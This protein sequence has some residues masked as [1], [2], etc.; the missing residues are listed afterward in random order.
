MLPYVPFGAP[1]EPPSSAA[2]R[3][4]KVMIANLLFRNVATQR[5]RE[6]VRDESPDVLLLIEFTPTWADQ[7]AELRDVYPYR[8]EK[9]E[10]GAFGMALLSRYELDPVAPLP[11]GATLAIQ[12]TI[13][14]PAGPF[15][16]IGVHL[17]SPTSRAWRCPA[18]P[19][20]RSP[21]SA[22]GQARRTSRRGRGFQR[23][24]VFAVLDRLARAHGAH[25][26]ALQA[27]AAPEL[28][29]ALA[30][31]R[32]PHRSFCREQGVGIVAYRRLPAFGSDH[33]PVLAE[34]AIAPPP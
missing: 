9:A 33:Y 6:I 7:I 1:P 17:R 23:D 29:R 31:A 32:H 19:A 8:F 34:L 4:V 24:A 10:R 11:F 15:T 26:G 28:A 16:M 5:L 2:Q 30:N 27:L 18:Q 13:R 21:R 14:S 20:A 12:A 25:R 22:S 3:P